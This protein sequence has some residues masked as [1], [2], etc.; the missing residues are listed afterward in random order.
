[1]APGRVKERAQTRPGHVAADAGQPARPQP[2]PGPQPVEPPPQQ[3]GCREGQDPEAPWREGE[4]QAEPGRQGG[5]RHRPRRAGPRRPARR[6]MAI[7][8]GRQR[9]PVG[10]SAGQR[11]GGRAR[12][13]TG[14]VPA[15]RRPHPTADRT[16]TGCGPDRCPRTAGMPTPRQ[17]APATATPG[18]AATAVDRR[19][20]EQ[21]AQAV[22]GEG[23]V[24][25]GDRRLEWAARRCRH[26][27]QLGQEGLR[28]RGVVEG[29]GPG[30]PRSGRPTARS[31]SSPGVPGAAISGAR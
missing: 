15:P 22:L 23:A 29:P 18:S 4:G 13:S 28:Q 16:T 3:P 6:V 31:S 30:R 14:S 26:G 17:A 21:V 9:G 20:A 10:V 19:H 8:D 11:R 2:G 12:V 5:Q 1:M 24:P 7:R 25:S 27:A